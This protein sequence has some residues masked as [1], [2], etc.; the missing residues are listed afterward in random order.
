MHPCVVMDRLSAAPDPA[1]F[2]P[3]FKL[4]IGDERYI[5]YLNSLSTLHRAVMERVFYVKDANGNQVPPPLPVA[6]AFRRLHRLRNKILSMIAVR[7]VLE[8]LEVHQ[9]YHGHKKKLYLVA[10]QEVEESGWNSKWR[11]VKSFVKREKY[12][13]SKKPDPVPRVIQPR[14][15]H[16][17][18]VLA[19]YLK[20]NE[21]EYYHAINR[22]VQLHTLVTTTSIAKGIDAFQLGDAMYDHWSSLKRPIAICIDAKRWDQ[23][24]S[25]DALK[26]EHSYYLI[27]FNYDRTLV[28]L[29]EMQLH[30][31]AV[32]PV[33][34]G[35]EIEGIL[36]YETDG[37]RMSGD[38]NTALG[39]VL[40]MCTITIAFMESLGIPPVF[41]NNGDDMIIFCEQEHSHRVYNAITPFYLD[42]GFEIEIE[43]QHEHL[44]Q[45]TFCQMNPIRTINGWLMCRDPRVVL[46]KDHHCI[47]PHLPYPVWLNTV[48]DGGRR[49]T[50]GAPVLPHFYSSLITGNTF[51]T[52]KEF[53]F[54]PKDLK[55]TEIIEDARYDFDLAFDI[56]YDSQIYLEELFQNMN[57]DLTES[58][59]SIDDTLNIF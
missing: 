44:Q 40:L 29:L 36:R 32:C 11:R 35:K 8:L 34:T 25:K 43:G 18:V 45:V 17:N 13:I 51:L 3:E 22:Y 15:P 58:S 24:V 14:D 56:D 42:Y 30:N 57:L 6:G 9:L 38:I 20:H 27:K 48:G 41:M 46:S 2:K 26:F 55:S 19:S 39:N 10:A 50:A 1:M 37:K 28:K 16:Y 54:T 33:Y 7:P 59:S 52:T 5:S 4:N 49:L 23:H 53:Y 31:K 47:Q 12:N 21:E